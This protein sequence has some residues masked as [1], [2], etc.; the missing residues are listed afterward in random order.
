VPTSDSWSFAER[1][2]RMA[3]FLGKQLIPKMGQLLATTAEKISAEYNRKQ[4]EVG[5]IQLPIFA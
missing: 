5:A 4:W 2:G 3:I 1:I